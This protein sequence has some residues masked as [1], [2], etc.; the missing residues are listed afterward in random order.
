MGMTQLQQ[1]REAAGMSRISLADRARVSR[2][3]LYEAERGVRE[4]SPKELAA[5]DRE[6]RREHEKAAQAAA[7]FLGAAV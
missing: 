3:R 5:I 2:F 1:L 6:L 7:E 4:L